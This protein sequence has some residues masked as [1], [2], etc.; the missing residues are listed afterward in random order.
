MYPPGV[1]FIKIKINSTHKFEKKHMF[2][3]FLFYCEVIGSIR[4][5]QIT[6]ATLNIG[7]NSGLLAIAD[8]SWAHPR[9]KSQDI[10]IVACQCVMS[11]PIVST[12]FSGKYFNKW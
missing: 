6:W 7:Q 5:H 4:W 9:G 8:L 12:V 10:T 3:F 1:D 2:F 11:V